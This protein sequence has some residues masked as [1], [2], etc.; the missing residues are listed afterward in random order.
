MWKCHCIA[1]TMTKGMI[2]ESM[3]SVV[4]S[5]SFYG[6]PRRLIVLAFVISSASIE[7]FDKIYS[8]TKIECHLTLTHSQAHLESGAKQVIFNSIIVCAPFINNFL[9]ILND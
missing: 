5:L 6:L 9:K 1:C 4:L 8:L 7:V 3:H 2:F